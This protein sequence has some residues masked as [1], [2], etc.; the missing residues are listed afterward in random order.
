MISLMVALAS[1]FSCPSGRWQCSEVTENYNFVDCLNSICS[2]LTSKG[3]SGNATVYNKCFCEAPKQVYWKSGVPRCIELD[4]GV[5]FS[6]DETRDAI[7]EEKVRTLYGSIIYPNPIVIAEQVKARDYSTGFFSLFHP[8]VKARVDPLGEYSSPRTIGEYFIG[9]TWT[10]YTRIFSHAIERLVV[11]GNEVAVHVILHF[12]SYASPGASVQPHYLFNFTQS[13]FITFSDDNLIIS[14][15]MVNRN[16]AKNMG[17]VF[18][19][20]PANRA[21]PCYYA[22][23]VSG[24]NSTYDPHGY[25]TSFEDCVQFMNSLEFGTFDDYRANTTLCRLYHAQMSQLDPEI[26][27]SHAGKTGGGKCSPHDRLD[28]YNVLY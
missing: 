7:L 19:D 10:G 11:K 28:Y 16:V 24:C 13:G 18:P 25:Y 14:M 12:G 21:V 27:C 20:K 1:S 15:N 5:S 23:T 4:D 22:V 3:F 26:H 8:N 17:N 9:S 6:L 2:C